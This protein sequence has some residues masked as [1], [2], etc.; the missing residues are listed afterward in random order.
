[1]VDVRII[2]QANKD[3]SHCYIEFNTEDE[4]KEVSKLD[5]IVHEGKTLFVAISKPKDDLVNTLYFNNLPFN[6]E[7]TDLLHALKDY[8]D[9][10]ASINLKRSYAFVKFFNEESM[11]KAKKAFKK[12]SLFIKGRKIVVKKADTKD[13]KQQDGNS[14]IDPANMMKSQTS[15]LKFITNL[16]IKCWVKENPIQAP[17]EETQK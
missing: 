2:P 15:N 8:K 10:I 9:D 14:Q 12:K 16:K 4:A 6:L 3:Y 1:M 13:D 11:K 17:Q 7:K 5:R